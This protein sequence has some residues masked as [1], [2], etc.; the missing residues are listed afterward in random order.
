MFFSADKYN[1]YL[2]LSDWSHVRLAL[3]APVHLNEVAPRRNTVMKAAPYASTA[4]GSRIETTP[5]P[6]TRMQSVR[7]DDP[8]GPD[9]I[10]IETQKLAIEANNAASPSKTHTE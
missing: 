1:A 3:F 4:I 9:E 2:F 7:A 10:R 8:M 6:N 5:M